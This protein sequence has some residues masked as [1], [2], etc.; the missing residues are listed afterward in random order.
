MEVLLRF[1]TTAEAA[2]TTAA[3]D[4]VQELSRLKPLLYQFAGSHYCEKARWALDYKG[5]E[6]RAKNLI[7]GPH[8]KSAR[9]IAKKTALPI[10]VDEARVV[11]GSAEIISYLDK[12]LPRPALTP[13]NTEDASMAYEWERYLD[14]NVG[15]PLRLLFYHYAFR[16]RALA[17]EFLLRGTAWW[18]RP[19]YFLTFPAIKRAMK[20]G[21]GIDPLAAEAASKQLL[22]AFDKLDERLAKH[23]F[24][25]GPTF[26]RA[27][28]TA[29]A[30][31]FHRWSEDW[32]PPPEFDDL[33]RPLEGRPFYQWAGNIYREYR[34]PV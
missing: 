10:L 7:P 2:S 27:D 32:Q 12:K 30:L 24:L 28:L 9:R 26:S 23:K 31:L 8:I 18:G 5:L 16:D 19:L 15:I 4:A 1:A 3:I 34:E 6:Y 14:R 25:A 11:Q 21:L 33:M 20:K 22:F 17:T 29:S 13:T